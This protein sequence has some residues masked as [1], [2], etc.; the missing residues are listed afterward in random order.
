[1]KKFINCDEFSLL[2]EGELRRFW[3]KVQKLDDSE[4]WNW[5][6][7]KCRFGHGQIRIR[8]R[9][10]RSHRLSFLIHRGLISDK[11]L[12]CHKC[13]NPKCVN[14]SHLFL[15]THSDNVK[16]MISKKRG[17]TENALATLRNH[18]ELRARGERNGARVHPESIARGMRKATS[19]LT[20]DDVRRIRYEYSNHRTSHRKIADVY[21][22]DHS[23]I[24][25]LLR[26]KTWRHIL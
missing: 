16:D 15:G 24:G 25:N 5:I 6:G 18:P 26:G 20:D 4:C 23:V 13:D 11:M 3:G 10:V 12:V 2:T 7:S 14:P 1:M 22:V 21:H 9:L 19:K 8:G 17:N